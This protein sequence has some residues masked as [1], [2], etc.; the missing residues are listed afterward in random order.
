MDYDTTL[1]KSFP[2][3]VIGGK[4]GGKH[5]FT[6]YEVVIGGVTIVVYLVTVVSQKS[7]S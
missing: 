6:W 3:L 1:K 7:V 5:W 4:Y 2:T